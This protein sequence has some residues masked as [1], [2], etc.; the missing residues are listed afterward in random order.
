MEIADPLALLRWQFRMTWSLAHDWFLPE[1][2]DELCLWQPRPA[3]LTVRPDRSGGWRADWST[4]EDGP[5][6]SVGWLTWHIIWWWTQTVAASDGAPVPSR[7]DVHWPGSA[8]A[9]V[10]QITG[11]AEAWTQRLAELTKPQLEVPVAFPWLVERPAAFTIAWV[12]S[13]LMK[14][15][16]EIGAGIRGYRAGT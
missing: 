11:L 14:N 15:V 4:D 7:D 5:A 6:P 1:L 3:S 12:N 9:A 2:T 10:L 8:A 16:A 13:E